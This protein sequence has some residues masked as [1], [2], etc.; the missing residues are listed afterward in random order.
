M[1][2]EPGTV[3]RE[4]NRLLAGL[5]VV[6]I[7]LLARHVQV[8]SFSPGVVLH[9][10]DDSP[11]WVYFPHGGVVSLL[12]TTSDGNSIEAASLGRRGVIGAILEPDDRNSLLA[13]VAL[14]PITASRV[15]ATHLQ[16]ASMECKELDRALQACRTNVLLRIR[17]NVVCVSLHSLERRVSR[18]L[19]E[20]ADHLESDRIS[21]PVT[22]DDVAERLGVRRTSVTLIAGKLQQAGAIR[23]GRSR[24]EIRDRAQLEAR[25][26]TC[27]ATLRGPPA[28]S[29][30]GDSKAATQRAR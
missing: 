27:Y 9:R 5:P 18:W 20:T 8:V 4:E 29:L 12:A 7:A 17:Q 23:W 11:D 30:L 1:L 2:T 10:Q 28:T 22:Q 25:T 6:E 13:A 19:L 16:T 14:G 3:C 21:I 24:V 15:A 26:C